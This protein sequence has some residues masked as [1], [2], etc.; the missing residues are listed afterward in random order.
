MTSNGVVAAIITLLCLVG[1]KADEALFDA[2]MPTVDAGCYELAVRYGKSPDQGHF[3][4]RNC[5]AYLA[6]RKKEQEQDV[7]L[8]IG[9]GGLP[10]R[11]NITGGTFTGTLY[12]NTGYDL[13]EV[14]VEIALFE[15]EEKKTKY[16]ESIKGPAE[17]EQ[18]VEPDE[19]R[20]IRIREAHPNLTVRDYSASIGSPLKF[21]TWGTVAGRGTPDPYGKSKLDVFLETLEKKKQA[22]N[23]QNGTTPE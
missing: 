11:A 5:L 7:S 20:R 12:N 9:M 21:W 14:T 19:V 16:E 6:E 15:T 22:A 23:S 10:G 3:L 2:P 8:A 13:S 4:L 17:S 1:C 18:K